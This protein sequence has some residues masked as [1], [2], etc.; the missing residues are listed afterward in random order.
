MF[1]GLQ[2]IHVYAVTNF[3]AFLWR[4]KLTFEAGVTF[5]T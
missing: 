2:E 4:D 5:R 1:A 3:S